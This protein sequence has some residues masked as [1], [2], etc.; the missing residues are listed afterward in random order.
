MKTYI[1]NISYFF[2]DPGC[3]NLVNQTH[4]LGDLES[5][6]PEFKHDQT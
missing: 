6:D 2:L 3:Y 1:G 5:G 4:V